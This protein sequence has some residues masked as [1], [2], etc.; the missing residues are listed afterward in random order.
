VKHY[1]AGEC[2]QADAKADYVVVVVVVVRGEQKVK[3]SPLDDHKQAAA[4]GNRL[5]ISTMTINNGAVSQLTNLRLV[6]GVVLVVVVDV[7]LLVIECVTVEV[8][9]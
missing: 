9:W 8:V 2:C 4:A 1:R 7:V 6:A 5:N 3:N